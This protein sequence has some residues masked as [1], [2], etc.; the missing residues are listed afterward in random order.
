MKFSNKLPL[1]HIFR[2][3]PKDQLSDVGIIW[4]V[5]KKSWQLRKSSVIAYF[6]GAA[7]EVGGSLLTLYA[8][9]RIASLLAQYIVGGE[10]YDIWLWVAIDAFS[11]VLMGLGFWLMS[12]GQKLL[13]FNFV[14]WSTSNYLDKLC[15]IDYPD[16]YNEETRNK[17]N[18]VEQSVSWQMANLSS[19]CLELG[20]GILRLL[21]MALVVA[22]IAWWLIPIIVVFL[23]PSLLAEK[24]IAS[25]SWF[26]WDEKGDQRHIFWNLFWIFKQASSQLEIRSQNV[27]NYLTSKI[28]SMNEDFYSTQEVKYK[29]ASKRVV[30]SKVFEIGG[31]TIGLIVVLNRFLS[32]KISFEQYFFLSGAL[33][34][35]G[36]AINAV[37]GTLAR[38]QEP[39][40]FAKTFFEFMDIKPKLIDQEAAQDI[41]DKGPLRIEFVNVSFTYPGS[42]EKIFDKL[43]LSIKPGEHVALVGENG[44]GKSTAIKL[45]LRFYKTDEGQILVNGKDINE[46]KIDSLYDQI[47]TL[48]QD[49]NRYPFPVKENVSMTSESN[50]DK[51]RFDEALKLGGLDEIIEEL[52]KGVNTVLD[53]S[54]KSGVEPSGGQYQRVALARTFYRKSNLIILDEPT[55][56]IDAKAEYKIFNNLFDHYKDITTLIVSHRF[57]TV[58][59][60]DRIVVLDKGKITEQGTHKQLMAKKGLYYELFSKQA[61]GYKD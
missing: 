55:S 39:L 48:F 13:Y 35:I 29:K 17:L 31:T 43:S 27:K 26:V 25:I 28:Y 1:P 60:A 5:Y 24:R 56:A 45:L 38:M 42:N 21:A 19:S 58:R 14:K 44:A 20:Y 7:L 49:F 33:F 16:Y 11:A 34:R 54:F 51:G 37:F 61:E 12:F 59:R 3:K 10:T 8:T 6:L 57:S 32:G 52:P 40:I 18:K 41:S 36:G 30:A 15:S 22:Q 53:S 2:L 50:I 47:A 46:I 4:R 23:L 9:A